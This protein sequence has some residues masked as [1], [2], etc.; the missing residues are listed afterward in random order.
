MAAER[1]RLDAVKVLAEKGARLDVKT[2]TGASVLWLA[3]R[4]G[5]PEAYQAV[6][7]RVAKPDPNEADKNDVTVLMAAAMGG[8]AAIINDLLDAGAKIEA[9]DRGG[10]TALHYA[11]S[12][13]RAEAVQALLDRKANIN[14]VRRTIEGQDREGS[15]SFS[16]SGWTTRSVVTTTYKQTTPLG[17]ATSNAQNPKLGDYSQVIEI[18]RKAGATALQ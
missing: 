6:K 9:G 7:A 11:A 18:L 15:M 10:G 5:N 14:A 1:G 4:G 2:V 16:S 3:A 12:H 13:N 8:S 17:I